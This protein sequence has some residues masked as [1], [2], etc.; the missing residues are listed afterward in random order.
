MATVD[1]CGDR[2]DQVKPLRNSKWKTKRITGWQWDTWNITLAHVSGPYHY[3]KLEVVIEVSVKTR[4]AEDCGDELQ[5]MV[6]ELDRCENNNNNN[7]PWGCRGHGAATYQI[8]NCVF[9]YIR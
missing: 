1:C 5:I 6:S 3:D 4:V 7:T 9:L 8:Y 2:F